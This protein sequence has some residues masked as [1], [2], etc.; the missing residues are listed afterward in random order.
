MNEK[1]TELDEL[2]RRYNIVADEEYSDE[3]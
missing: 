2:V 3:L 1:R